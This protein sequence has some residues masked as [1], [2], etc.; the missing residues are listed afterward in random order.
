MC[1]E[2]VPRRVRVCDAALAVLRETGN[3]AVMWGD[4]QLLHLIADRAGIKQKGAWETSTRVLNA[5]SRQPGELVPGL[6]RTGRNRV[7]RI[8]RKQ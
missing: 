1:P 8:F 6:T 5:L 7:V 4:E 3:D 2:S